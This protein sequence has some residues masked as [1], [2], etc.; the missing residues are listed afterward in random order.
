MTVEFEMRAIV[1]LS[2]EDAKEIMESFTDQA[3]DTVYDWWDGEFYSIGEEI[4]QLNQGYDCVAS[5]IGVFLAE[6]WRV[7]SIDN[8]LFEKANELI[9]ELN[10][11][12][13]TDKFKL[14]VGTFTW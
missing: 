1:G 9:E 11:K 12:Y 10:S 14:Y 4:E 3:E 13:E 5:H 6:G 7:I 8:S 2:I